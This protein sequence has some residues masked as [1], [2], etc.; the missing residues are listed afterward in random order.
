MRAQVMDIIKDEIQKHT[1]QLFGQLLRKFKQRRTLKKNREQQKVV[2]HGVACDICEKAPITGI[3][4][5][6]SVRNNYDVCQ[7]CEINNPQ[8]HPMIKIRDPSKA[9]LKVFTTVMDMVP[10]Q[11]NIVIK[12]EPGFMEIV[13]DASREKLVMPNMG[14][15]PQAP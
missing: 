12:E 15:A 14:M 7:E 2:H 11:K 6:C 9:P 13:Q 4:Y 8:P 10:E 5:K 1:P 3:R